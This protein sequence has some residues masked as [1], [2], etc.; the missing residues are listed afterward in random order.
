MKEDK[1]HFNKGRVPWNKG[2]TNIYSEETLEKIREGRK[3]QYMGFWV[4]DG[5]NNRKCYDENEIPNGFYRGKNMEHLNGT[6]KNVVTL[7]TYIKKYGADVGALKWKDLCE[8]RKGT[9][10]NFIKKYGVD[11]GTERY[12]ESKR[13]KAFAATVDYYIR[14]YGEEYGILR[15]KQFCKSKASFSPTTH[16]NN[17]RVSF[18]AYKVFLKIE[19]RIKLF[20]SEFTSIYNTPSDKKFK[21]Y[22][23]YDAEKNKRYFYDFRGN[24]GN[25]YKFVIE[26]NGVHVH[27]KK[28]LVDGWKHAFT[29]EQSEV[30]FQ[31][32]TYKNSLL[33]NKNIDLFIIWS[34]EKEDEAIER[35]LN[36]IIKKNRI[37]I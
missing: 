8:R 23:I 36:E 20:D 30:V 19:Q 5:T 24:L 25:G 2:K 3:K 37:N 29:K 18:S 34:D 33:A 27:P 28:E 21:E 26:Y 32:D 11:V 10:E 13:K 15:W 7:E 6:G 16:P 14:K 17:Y 1:E 31:R 22:F 4:T 35:I 9:L 12:E